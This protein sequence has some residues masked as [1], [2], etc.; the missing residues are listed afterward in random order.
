[1]VD[2][3]NIM[4]K[5]KQELINEVFEEITGKPPHPGKGRPGGN[6]DFG[7][8]IG[9][10]APDGQEPNSAKLSMRIKQSTLDKLKS[11]DNWQDAVRAA[12]EDLVKDS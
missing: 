6:P 2:Y 1:M 5:I 7:K 12:L 9:F 3:L 4:D 11:L 8:K 10:K